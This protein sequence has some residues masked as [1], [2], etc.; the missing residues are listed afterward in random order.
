MKIRLTNDILADMIVGSSIYSTGGGTELSLQRK[1]LQG[2]KGNAKPKLISID[3][4]K[5][6]D[7]ICTAYSV[8][9]TANTGTDITLVLRS[10][11]EEI[12]SLVNKKMS[13]IFAGETNIDARVF[14]LAS[15]MRL[16][17]VDGDATGGRAVPLI[18]IDNFNVLG[19][20]SLP[21]CAVNSD[22]ERIILKDGNFDDAENEV[23]KLAAKSKGSVGVVDHSVSVA[24][25]KKALTLGIFKRS[26]ET[27]KFIR[28]NRKKLEKDVSPLVTR[29][30][31]RVVIEGTVSDVSL[32]RSA[33]FLEGHYTI[34][35][36]NGKQ[37]KVY[38]QNEN[39]ACWLDGRM[40]IAPPDSIITIDLNE[41]I[42]V[43]NSKIYKGE[44]VCVVGKRA[45][46]L[47]R[48]ATGI[49]VF[50]PKT[51]KLKSSL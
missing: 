28:E 34:Q 29:I 24:D 12:E 27:G 49:K 4:L 5:D 33:R 6:S 43:H 25:A 32:S 19:K 20:K 50:G 8:G 30:K 13:A 10:A 35:G 31:G 1:L 16:P 36:N 23:T 37:L 38:V 9:A 40:V 48:T 39:I 21:L 51:F 44:K 7:Y 14:L 47:W 26:L 15:S 3:E 17:V 46:K 18:Q 11:M 45:S 41:L 22:N 2:L 42:G